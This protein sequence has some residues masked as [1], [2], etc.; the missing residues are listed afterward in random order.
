MISLA[1]A[2]SG[3][4]GAQ[5]E[6]EARMAGA[7][8]LR[9]V[10]DAAPM[11]SWQVVTARGVGAHLRQHPEWGGAC[12]GQCASRKRKAPGPVTHPAGGIL[13]GRAPPSKSPGQ[14]CAVAH[15]AGVIGESRPIPAP[16]CISRS[17]A[18][19]GG[20]GQ[21]SSLA[22]VRSPVFDEILERRERPRS[23]APHHRTEQR[24]E[25]PAERTPFDF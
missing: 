14:H 5:R 11:L 12:P 13:A 23:H 9:R 4:A 21:V 1:R 8:T 25:Q 24:F 18:R 20:A 10:A 22:G 15:G 17:G 3:Q 2:D 6:S 16:R 7:T 19:H